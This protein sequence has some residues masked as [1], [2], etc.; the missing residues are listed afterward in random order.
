MGPDGWPFASAD[1]FPGADK[2]PFYGFKHAKELYF[3]AEPDYSGRSVYL[4][5]TFQVASHAE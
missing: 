5:F 4:P 3:K 2:E 1:D